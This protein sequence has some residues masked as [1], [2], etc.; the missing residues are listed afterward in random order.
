MTVA[1]GLLAQEAPPTPNTSIDKLA[2]DPQW[3][4]LLHYD[5]SDKGGTFLTSDFYLSP[6]GRDQPDAELRAT[7]QAMEIPVTDNS[8]PRCRFP[9]RYSWLAKQL[10]RPA[11]RAIPPACHQLRKWLRENPLRSVSLLMVS[12]YMGNPASMFG[13]SILKINTT[14]E[15]HDLFS[16]T[17]NYGALVPPKES[18]IVYI[19]RGLFGG[20]QAGYSDRY[21]YTQDVVYTNTEA[22]DIWEYELN[23]SPEQATFLQLHL[24]EIIGKK[25]QYFFLTRNCAYELGRVIDVV[26]DRPL[27][28]S[29]RI[30]YTPSELFDRLHDIDQEARTSQRESLI[31]QLSYHPSAERLL[32]HDYE[33]LGPALKSRAQRFLNRPGIDQ[34]D[35]ALADLAAADQQTLLDFL[36]SYQHFVFTKEQPEPSPETLSLK[37]ALLVK[38]LALP[39]SPEFDDQPSYRPS[40]SE[41][42]KP[43]IIGLGVTTRKGSSA[44]PIMKLTAFSQ[45][46]TGQNA[47]NGGE[48]TVFDLRLDLSGD[49]TLINRVDY[50]RIFHHALSP[51]PM[52][53]PWSWRLLLRSARNPADQYDHQLYLGMGR[54]KRVGKTLLYGLLTP[55]IHSLSPTLRLRPETG[56]IVSLR[57]KLRAHLNVGLENSETGWQGSALGTLQYSFSREWSLQLEYQKEAESFWQ[58]SMRSHW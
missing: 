41:G 2:V 43:S 54:S 45:E 38:R 12:G 48:L 33:N 13:H 7:I 35:I 6:W 57:D 51:L 16:T 3:L 47:L 19:F 20:Y 27:T 17:I 9:A 22:R 29:A 14:T 10:R 11:W 18:I 58:L 52:A 34:I 40:P 32:I 5:A 1:P 53:S 23:L 50:L 37:H 30:W 4:R 8:H 31:K 21:F 25:K 28:R 56:I 24:W 42:Q 36:F 49:G 39:P 44:A 15:E 46:P 55:S 26:T